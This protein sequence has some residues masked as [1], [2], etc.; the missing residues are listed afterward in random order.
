MRLIDADKLIK[1]TQKRISIMKKLGTYESGV[2]PEAF[3][4]SVEL[5]DTVD[6]EPVR[7]GHWKTVIRHEHYPSGVE[8][9]ADY[10]SECSG[11]GSLEYKFCPNCGARMIKTEGS[12]NENTD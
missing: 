6:V 9:E 7:H 11:R 8:Y 12:E 10:C 4:R 3:I 2:S 5:E 1:N